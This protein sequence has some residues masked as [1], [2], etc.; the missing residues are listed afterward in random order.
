YLLPP[1]YEASAKILVE[2]QVIPTDL[3]QPTVT[4]NVMERI[5]AI[6]QRLM[7]RDNLLEIIRKFDLYPSERRRKS[8][9]EI[10]DTMRAAAAITPIDT[11]PQHPSRG[12]EVIGFTVSFDYPDPD[13]ASRV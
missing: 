13:L 6:E 12:T 10:I 1:V 2:S 5:Q 8:P 7:T 9:S 4:A 11:D 3:A